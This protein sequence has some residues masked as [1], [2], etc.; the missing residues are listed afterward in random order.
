MSMLNL[1]RRMK[2]KLSEQ[3]LAA[4]LLLALAFVLGL[5]AL[6]AADTSSA[7]KQD[8]IALF[9]DDFKGKLGDG[10]SWI[11]EHREAWRVGDRSLEVRIEPGNMW[12]PQNNA[13][14]V[15][16]RPAPSPAQ[17]EIE[18]SVNVENKPTSQYEQV[19]LVW[20]YDDSNMVKLGL[21][22]VDGKLSVVMGR[23][24]KD[25]TRTIAIVPVESTSLSL[26]F[27]V[28]KDQIRGQ[29]R[30]TG[31]HDWREVGE[32]SL[33]APAGGEPMISLQFYQGPEKVEHWA[34]ITE[35]QVRKVR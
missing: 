10:W 34:R 6:S 29:F 8:G 35:F 9:R 26:R 7:A 30:A 4:F 28:K 3:P 33:P 21:E 27:F 16:V 18:V 12:G 1:N 25:K 20:Y 2:T 23:E 14:N 5:T 19:D 31:A 13:K 24:E 15:L 11:R 17:G 32:C 22:L